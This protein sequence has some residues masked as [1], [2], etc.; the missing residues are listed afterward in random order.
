[1]ALW[2]LCIVYVRVLVLFLVG[3]EKRKELLG[4]FVR[5]LAEELCPKG[6]KG[7]LEVVLLKVF[8]EGFEAV[9]HLVII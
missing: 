7:L 3:L 8:L 5:N 2:V 9:N 6:V 4:G 1:M